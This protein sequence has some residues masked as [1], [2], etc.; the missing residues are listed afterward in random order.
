LIESGALRSE[1]QANG[2][3]GLG[4]HGWSKY[5]A[6]SQEHHRQQF[7]FHFVSCLSAWE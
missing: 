4:K 7:R 5:G 1:A 2:E 3:A 6:S